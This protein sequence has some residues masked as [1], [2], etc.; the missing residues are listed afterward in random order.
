[1]A[2]RYSLELL[3]FTP[4]SAKRQNI[5]DW[6][7]AQVVGRTVG[8]SLTVI[9]PDKVVRGDVGCFAEVNEFSTKLDGDTIFDGLRARAIS[10]TIGDAPSGAKSY[11]RF[12]ETDDVARTVTRRLTQS[13]AWADDPGTVEAL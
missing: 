12:T 2:I 9:E 11:I 8:A 4:S 7:T 13:P 10:Q 3:A 5:A 6:L 1:M